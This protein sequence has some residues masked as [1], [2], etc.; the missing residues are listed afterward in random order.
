M[1]QTIKS[2]LKSET[3][4][5]NEDIILLHGENESNIAN[6]MIN[7]LWKVLK[8]L[9]RVFRKLCIIFTKKWKKY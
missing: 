3:S 6:N 4:N 2:L 7:I 5:V 9:T 8:K 1:S